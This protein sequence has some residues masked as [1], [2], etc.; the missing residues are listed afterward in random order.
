MRKMNEVLFEQ[1]GDR[2]FRADDDGTLSLIDEGNS[3]CVL[4]QNFFAELQREELGFQAGTDDATI[5]NRSSENPEN[6][7]KLLNAIASRLNA[8][9][10]ILEYGALQNQKIYEKISAQVT[11]LQL[12]GDSDSREV[13]TLNQKLQKI[14]DEQAKIAL[15]SGAA[16]T[17]RQRIFDKA[18]LLDSYINEKYRRCFAQKL[19]AARKARK[20][21]QNS[22]SILAGIPRDRYSQYE[23]GRAVP[24]VITAKRL[25]TTLRVSLDELF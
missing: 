12:V 4:S 10:P 21:T 15:L 18:N 16:F 20:M 5:I 17:L 13:E 7:Q 8:F 3:D 19:T 9:L 24:S 22:F 11:T 2:V 23:T 14:L 25:A 6:D 1:E